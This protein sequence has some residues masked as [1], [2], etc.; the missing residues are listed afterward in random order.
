MWENAFLNI[1]KCYKTWNIR[2]PKPKV[3]LPHPQPSGFLISVHLGMKI[4]FNFFNLKYFSKT[5]YFLVFLNQCN[6]V[7]VVFRWNLSWVWKKQIH[8]VKEDCKLMFFIFV[9]WTNEIYY[10]DL[11]YKIKLNSFFAF[12]THWRV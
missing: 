5:N 9:S 2:T 6:L 3:P 12:Q 1:Q 7:I 11:F 4:A 8:F 10:L